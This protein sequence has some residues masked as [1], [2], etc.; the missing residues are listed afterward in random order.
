MNIISCYFNLGEV[1]EGGGDCSAM[2]EIL[3]LEVYILGSYSD[4]VL[5]ERF[6]IAG[7]GYIIFV[8][9]YGDGGWDNDAD[10]FF[11]LSSCEYLAGGPVLYGDACH[12]NLVLTHYEVEGVAM[13][14]LHLRDALHEEGSAFAVGQGDEVGGAVTIARH[15]EGGVGGVQATVALCVWQDFGAAARGI[16]VFN[17]AGFA[18]DTYVAD[19]LLVVIVLVAEAADADNDARHL[20]LQL[21]LDVAA[22]LRTGDDLLAGHVVSEGDILHAALVGRQ[23]EAGHRRASG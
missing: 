21:H 23:G 2:H 22:A 13:A 12:L 9:R 15:D 14:C 11:S 6:S 5:G 4:T 8:P 17:A 3:I 10:L 18:V 16:A 20:A 1:A 7:S 19:G